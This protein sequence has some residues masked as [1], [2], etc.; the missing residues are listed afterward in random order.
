VYQQKLCAVCHGPT[1]TDGLTPRLV[2]LEAGP[3][4][5]P[6]E[7]GRILPIRAPYATGV[8]DFINRGMPLNAEGT[9]TADEVYVLTAYLLYLNDLIAEDDVLDA[10]SL[11][12]VQMPNRDGFALLPDWKPGQPWVEGYPY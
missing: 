7:H 2:K 11:P 8:W 10:Q 9:L 1:G 5:D 12:M 4:A 6:W 3:D